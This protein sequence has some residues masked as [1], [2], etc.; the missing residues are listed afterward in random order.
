MDKKNVTT[1]K[2]KCTFAK[3]LDKLPKK[4]YFIVK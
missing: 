4:D 3:I 1:I 2:K